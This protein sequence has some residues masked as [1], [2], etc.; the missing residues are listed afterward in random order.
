MNKYGIGYL[1]VTKSHMVADDE[2]AHLKVRNHGEAFI[3]IMDEYMPYWRE[4]RKKLNDSTLDY[5]PEG[6]SYADD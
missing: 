1:I 6:D 4:T 3:A 2:L 5:L